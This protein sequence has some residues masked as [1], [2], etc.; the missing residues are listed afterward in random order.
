M[1]FVGW[2]RRLSPA[3]VDD[4]RK[5]ARER[6]TRVEPAETASAHLLSPSFKSRLRHLRHHHR[7]DVH[8]VQQ[9]AT[10]KADGETPILTSRTNDI[11]RREY[12]VL[13]V[14]DGLEAGSESSE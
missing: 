5:T 6:L 9:L 10:L 1:R 7:I 12:Q 8:W 13:G 2:A 4:A 14:R 3:Q 11:E